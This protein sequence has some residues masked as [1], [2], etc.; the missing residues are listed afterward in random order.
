MQQIE[1][2]LSASLSIFRSS[3]LKKVFEVVLAFGNYMNSSKP[4]GAAWGFKLQ[5]LSRV[6]AGSMCAQLAG[7]ITLHKSRR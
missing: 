2:V 1:A 5:S 6:S 4:Q 7:S 3:R